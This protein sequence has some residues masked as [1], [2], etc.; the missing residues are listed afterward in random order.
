MR[1][2]RCHHSALSQSPLIGLATKIADSNAVG[3]TRGDAVWH[4]HMM[5]AHRQNGSAHGC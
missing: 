2:A 3:S 4:A 5:S 1:F